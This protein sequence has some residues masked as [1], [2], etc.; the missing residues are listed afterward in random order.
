VRGVSCYERSDQ[1]TPASTLL[2]ED[3][4]ADFSHLPG[5][6]DFVEGLNETRV[7]TS[8]FSLWAGKY[9]GYDAKKQYILSDED[10]LNSAPNQKRS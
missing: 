1:R 9:F 6:R 7:S 2:S 10:H 8:M 4:K 3:K 5:L